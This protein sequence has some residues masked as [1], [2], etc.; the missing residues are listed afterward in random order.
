MRTIKLKNKQRDL[1]VDLLWQEYTFL[2]DE[3]EDVSNVIDM[4]K[5]IG[6]YIP[7][8]IAGVSK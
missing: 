2:S 5:R 3:N 6:A 4:L 7:E 1:M 8:D